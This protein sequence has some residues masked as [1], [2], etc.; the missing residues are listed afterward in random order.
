MN[1]VERIFHLYTWKEELAVKLGENLTNN[2]LTT[3]KDFGWWFES[4]SFNRK[5]PA[6]DDLVAWETKFAGIERSL[7]KK[8]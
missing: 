1:I 2:E 5:D 6:I 3:F 8:A 4:I 7:L